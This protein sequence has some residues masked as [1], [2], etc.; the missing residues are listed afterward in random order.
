MPEVRIVRAGKHAVTLLADIRENAVRD[1]NDA[2]NH[3][4]NDDY[5]GLHEHA[6]EC[7]THYFIGFENHLPFG[8]I[9][10]SIDDGECEVIGPYLYPDYLR[11]ELQAALIEFAVEY[12]QNLKVRLVYALVLTAIPG[13]MEAFSGARFEDISKT[14]S[15]SNDGMTA[16]SLTGQCRRRCNFS[17]EFSSQAL[18]RPIQNETLFNQINLLTPPASLFSVEFR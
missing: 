8:Y 16:S 9:R 12:M 11:S 10:I 6:S 4:A 7:S 18:C 3:F 14:P 5:A 17:P 15:L 2:L 13:A 1:L